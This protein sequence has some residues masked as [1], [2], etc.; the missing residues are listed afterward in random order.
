MN[1]R[2]HTYVFLS[3]MER[4]GIDQLDFAVSWRSNDGAF[5][6]TRAPVTIAN[7]GKQLSWFAS[8]NIARA[9]KVG[10]D[11]Y[12]RP[13]RGNKWP[14]VMLDDLTRSI[15]AEIVSRHDSCK[16]ETSKNNYQ[17]W[18][19][20][21]RAI[22]ES[23]RL[24]MQQSLIQKYG[25]DP[26][27]A[28]GEHF[29]RLPGFRNHKPGRGGF[30]VSVRSAATDQEPLQVLAPLYQTTTSPPLGGRV[31]SASKLDSGS[32][33][34]SRSEFGYCCK[35][36]KAGLPLP[37]V[38]AAITAHAMSRRGADTGRYVE[39][40]LQRACAAVGARYCGP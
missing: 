13:A 29:G 34:P 20:T 24:A 14:V 19:R 5:L 36:L 17:V 35:A 39:R 30:W 18:I 38:R 33:D 12:V 23:E 3:W 9:D 21:D 31:H 37:H 6:P 25:G 4:T 2:E 16:I 1:A 32:H 8:Q 28:S 40:T 26:G 7:V 11:I 22:S 27:S 10:A 15:A